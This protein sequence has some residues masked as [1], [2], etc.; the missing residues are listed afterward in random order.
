MEL[1]Y[2]TDANVVPSGEKHTLKFRSLLPSNLD[3]YN[4][5]LTSHKRMDLS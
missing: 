5:V 1:S 3:F 2:L 4:P